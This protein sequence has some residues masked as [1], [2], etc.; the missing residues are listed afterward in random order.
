V[1]KYQSK[2]GLDRSATRRLCHASSIAVPATADVRYIGLAKGAG[3]GAVV[4]RK[5]RVEDRDQYR[6]P[7]SASRL[8]LPELIRVSGRTVEDTEFDLL[9]PRGTKDAHV[10]YSGDLSLL[11]RRAVSVVGSREVSPDGWRRAARELA[12]SGI[13][14]MSGL[15]KGVDTAALTTAIEAGGRC[16]AI[17]GTPLDEAYP[18][19]NTAPQEDIYTRHLLIS[20]FPS[21]ERVRRN[22][23]PERNRVMALLSDATVIVEASDSSGALHQAAE[24]L[25]QSR[26]LFIMKSVVDDPRLTWPKKFIGK[27]KVAVLS[28]TSEIADAIGS[29]HR[30]EGMPGA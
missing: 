23:F 18:V 27:P 20:P 26:W 13:V 12:A 6:R 4:A 2:A 7:Q 5:G 14:V 15:A 9:R 11:S 30:Q 10:Y 1:R 16:V 8:L 28:A 3:M 29:A 25:R 19:E 24:C 21:G 17:I 22:N